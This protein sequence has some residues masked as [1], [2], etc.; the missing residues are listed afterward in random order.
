MATTIIDLDDILG[1]DKQV[2]LKGKVYRLPPDLPV[3]LYLKIQRAAGQDVTETEI[4]ETLYENILELFRYKQP[5]LK[6]LP[7]SLAQLVT[8]I[9]TIY[10]GDE[11]ADGDAAPPPRTRGGRS[12]KS[13]AT[14]SRS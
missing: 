1:A 12:S 4:F 3:E 7:L 11:A 10:G 8:A 2:R 5:G 6:E 13:A 9:P 14:K